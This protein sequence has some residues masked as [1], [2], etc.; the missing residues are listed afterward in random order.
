MMLRRRRLPRGF[1]PYLIE[2]C[3]DETWQLEHFPTPREQAA[4]GDQKELAQ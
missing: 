1:C 4:L 2:N 3:V